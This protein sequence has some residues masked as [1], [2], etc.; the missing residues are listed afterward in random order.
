MKRIK[1][2]G[3]GLVALLLVATVQGAEPDPSGA[4]LSLTPSQIELAAGETTRSLVVVRAGDGPLSEVRL[5]V[6]EVPGLQLS[7]SPSSWQE[8]EAGGS[9]TADVVV[10]RSAGR[11]ASGTVPFRLTW[12]H[13][14]ETDE[15]KLATGV[16]VQSL[17]VE[18]AGRPIGE[19]AELTVH[20][21][22]ATIE[23]R[24]HGGMAYVVVRNLTSHQLQV[25]GL[26][27][28]A[29][30]FLHVRHRRPEPP[31]PEL[32]IGIVLSRLWDR[33][34]SENGRSCLAS[35]CDAQAE[36]AWS[37]GEELELPSVEAGSSRALPFQI[38]AEAVEPGKHTVGWEV[39]L[40][41]HR[42]DQRQHGVAVV[43]HD[44]TLGVLGESDL[45]KLFAW[46]SVLVLPGAL[47]L[48]TV[49]TLRKRVWPR[50]DG[51]LSST[52]EATKAEFWLIAIALS[53]LTALVYPWLTGKLG[54]P[55]DF[56]AVHGLDDIVNLWLGS[57]LVALLAWA[58]WYGGK[59]AFER[60]IG[61]LERWREGRRLPRPGDGPMELLRK[62]E[63]AGR[64]D[65][66]VN[67]ATL[68]EGETGRH[69]LVL[70]DLG[71]EGAWVGPPVEVVYRSGSV[72][73]RLEGLRD[74]DPGELLE[75][76]EAGRKSGEVVRVRWKAEGTMPRGLEKVARDALE[77]SSDRRRLVELRPADDDVVS[78]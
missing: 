7:L 65:L 73:D 10:Q 28:Y 70:Y 35:E 63:R 21:A 75:V 22:I 34:K 47:M 76:L 12:S 60:S 74:G 51:G 13:P 55:R 6:T 38:T 39:E 72:Q 15:E 23:D 64:P 9:R 24:R 61:A 29:P 30:Y 44:F 17:E 40:A 27:C 56:I 48:L 71:E 67:P 31:E 78:G 43:V 57:I 11:L 58:S 26:R 68:S 69:A 3:C 33:M 1:Q 5:H 49:A 14:S 41:W 4:E 36:D 2:V 20:S 66:L 32:W 59:L 19:I 53:F 62:L 50:S 42:G 16:V 25:T 37:C 8:I 45:L 52:D 46:P 77:R 18:D 54:D